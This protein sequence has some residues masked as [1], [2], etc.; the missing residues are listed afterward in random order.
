MTFGKFFIILSLCHFVTLSLFADAHAAVNLTGTA[1]VEKTAST[2]AAAKS[3]ATDDARRQIAIAVLSRYSDPKTISML[4]KNAS[5]S[6]MTGLIASSGIDNEKTSATAYSANFT[7]TLDPDATAKWLRDNNVPNYM[8][9]ADNSGDRAIIF[10]NIGGL[11]QWAGLKQKLRDSDMDSEL[12]LKTMQGRN[13][14]ATIPSA[15]RE[16]FVNAL[17]SLG[18][19][20]TDDNGILRATR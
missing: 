16:G 4:I 1:S 13:I 8:S 6:D 2:A 9:A 18:W 7:M 17:R 15:R 11:K 3:L 19:T 5:D 10:F 12:E 14:S 20:V